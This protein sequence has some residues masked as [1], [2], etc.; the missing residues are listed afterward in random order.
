MVK[1]WVT[2]KL[3]GKMPIAGDELSSPIPLLHCSE[4]QNLIPVTTLCISNKLYLPGQTVS[5]TLVKESCLLFI[6][7]SHNT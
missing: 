2:L 5:S 1:F 7:M 4:A 3:Q 6:N